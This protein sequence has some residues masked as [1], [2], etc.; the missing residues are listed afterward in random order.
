MLD[1]LT[2]LTGGN[3]YIFYLI[4]FGTAAFQ[5]YN[6][7][8]NLSSLFPPP[9][10]YYILGILLVIGIFISIFIFSPNLLGI[11]ET[12]I[13]DTFDNPMNGFLDDFGF[14]QSKNNKQKVKDAKFL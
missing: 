5:F 3:K 13:M 7:Y 9:M 4:S 11:E 1:I 2:S 8:Q 14:G 6:I 10:K 12:E